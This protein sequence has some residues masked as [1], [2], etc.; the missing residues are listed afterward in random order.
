[1]IPK[2]L[3]EWLHHADDEI[4]ARFI[5]NHQNLIAQ[6]MQAWQRQLNKEQAAHNLPDDAAIANNPSPL[7]DNP[8]DMADDATAPR[9][10]EGE[11]DKQTAS[12]TTATA[13][14]TQENPQTDDEFAPL[15]PATPTPT[16]AQTLAIH[17]PPLPNANQGQPYAYTL[18]ADLPITSLTIKIADSG[19]TW[20]D[21]TRRIYGTPTVSGDLLIRLSLLDNG[22]EIGIHLN[23]HI[24]PDPKSLWQ[25]L[26]SDQDAP[27]AK[28]D[29]AHEE[30][31]TPHGR[32]IAARQRGRSHAHIGSYCDDDYRLHYH[33]ASGLHLLTVADGAGSAAHSRYGSQLA[34]TAVKNTIIAL[35]DDAD[36]PHHRLAHVDPAQRE[37]IAANLITHALHAAHKAHLEAAQQHGLGAKSLSCTLLIGLAVALPDGSWYHAAYQVGD[38]TAALWQ[39]E[40]GTLHLLGEADSGA[41]SGKIQFLSRAQLDEA[42]I[43]R[44]IRHHS[45][46]A[47]AALILMTDG[48]SFPK[49]EFE[50][51]A[52]LKNPALWQTL[53]QELKTPLTAAAPDRALLDWL[54]F[55]SRGSHDDRTI[56]L[57]APNATLASASLTAFSGQDTEHCHT[58]PQ[59]RSSKAPTASVAP[60]TIACKE[61][62][63]RRLPVYIC[64]DTSGSM[65]GEPIKAVNNGLRAMLAALEQNSYARETV[66][67]TLITF[68]NRVQEVLP[69]T[70]LPEISLPL[71]TCPTSGATFLGGALERI[72]AI[73]PRD[74]LHRQDDWR[75][76]LIL[77]TDGK[78]SDLLAYREMIPVIKLLGFGNIVAC[79]AGPRAEPRYLRE[80]T[81]TVVSL[82]TMDANAFI[83]F[84]R[85][86]STKII[87]DSGT[88]QESNE[89]P[90]IPPKINIDF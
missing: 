6:L 80:L 18:P 89:L 11:D 3:K 42:D 20:D 77:L 27:F 50:T 56:A 39:P 64:I 22:K 10:H 13:S 9:P 25:N 45:D 35:L 61:T 21:D 48:V 78:P 62:S 28:P 85:W 68:D 1:M 47:P 34:V 82:D 31:T 40:S 52:G 86:V 63:L 49:F 81:D 67:L 36:K 30:Q 87:D 60:A 74:H 65:R 8:D 51:D 41:Y 43:A 58:L 83:R 29:S 16:A 4:L 5:A 37:K 19:L 46:S 79:A 53:W 23:L 38:G 55:W 7:A 32:L 88:Q 2:T 75:P 33:E 69:L 76:M 66:H 44:R 71:I 54:V 57:F 15:D 59:K 24:N 14:I 12:E 72:A 84:F 26:P 70:P 17:L 73:V 90:S